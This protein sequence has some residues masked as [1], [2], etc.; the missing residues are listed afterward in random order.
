MK[1]AKIGQIGQPCRSTRLDSKLAPQR[2]PLAPRRQQQG[3]WQN[4]FFFSSADIGQLDISCFDLFGYLRM[5]KT[6]PQ[7]IKNHSNSEI[8]ERIEMR[9][10]YCIQDSDFLQNFCNLL[11][12][13]FF[14]VLPS[15]FLIVHYVFSYNYARLELYID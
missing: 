9:R 12:V 11:L 7:G 6:H 15:Q 13:S 10:S 2:R 3:N 4:F 1:H 14:Y 8:K 5:S